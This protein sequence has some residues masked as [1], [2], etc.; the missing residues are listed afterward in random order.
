MNANYKSVKFNFLFCVCILLSAFSYGQLANFSLQV[1][2]TNE[3]CAGNGSLQFSTTGTTLG[4]SVYY[5]LYL[6]PDTTIPIAVTNATA[7]TGLT[8][9]NYR[10][11]ALLS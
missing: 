8:T 11:V 10:V 2:A 7:L 1:T 4:A 6:L 5:S 3:T 9:G